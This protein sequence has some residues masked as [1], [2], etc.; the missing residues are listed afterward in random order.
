MQRLAMGTLFRPMLPILKLQSSN[1][2][3]FG[4]V[5]L[6]KPLIHI[7]NHFVS[8]LILR[9]TISKGRIASKDF[10]TTYRTDRNSL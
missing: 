2:H 8:Q 1:A 10:E 3:I 6:G 4:D 7:S 9:R 5:E